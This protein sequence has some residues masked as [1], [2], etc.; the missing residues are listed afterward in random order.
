MSAAQPALLLV[1]DP[2]QAGCLIDATRRRLLELL[3][4][5]DSATGLAR[6]LG[7][8]RQRINYHLRE[9]ERIGLVHCVSERRKGNCTERLMQTT[10]QAFVISPEVLGTLGPTPGSSPDRLSAAT[11]VGAAAETIRSVAILERQATDQGKS[12]ATLTLD[13]LIRFASPEARAAFAAELTDAVAHLVARY[14]N[15]DAPK[16]R[17]FRLLVGSH[18]IV[19]PPVAGKGADHV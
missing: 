9:L 5:P 18:P 1:R 13:A 14:H 3:H 4:T 11:L 12:F 7:L 6:Q 15:D 10:A 19:Q 8:P 16:G 17:T 2:G